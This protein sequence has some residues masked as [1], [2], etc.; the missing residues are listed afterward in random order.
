MSD[1]ESIIRLLEEVER[2][3]RKIGFCRDSSRGLA[4]FLASALVLKLWDLRYPLRGQIVLTA[5]GT[6][7]AALVARLGWRWFHKQRLVSIAASIDIK[8]Q[9]NDGMKSA[10]WFLTAPDASAQSSSWIGLHLHRTA[11]QSRRIDA[12]RLYPIVLPRGSYIA[13]ILFGAVVILNFMPTR[14]NHNWIYLKTAPAFALTERETMLVEQTQRLL[15]QGGGPRVA[16]TLQQTGT[17]IDRLESGTITL[18]EGLRRLDEI[19]HALEET[20]LDTAA[21]QKALA[22]IAGEFERAAPM[23]E[24]ARALKAP[25]LLTAAAQLRELADRLGRLTREE[26][27]SVRET[28]QHAAKADT[29]G[30]KT[31][32]QDFKQAAETGI[33]ESRGGMQAWLEKGAREL[34]A[35]D[36]QMHDQGIANAAGMEIRQL[37]AELGHHGQNDP[38]QSASSETGNGGKNQVSPQQAARGSQDTPGALADGLGPRDEAGSRQSTNLMPGG[39]AHAPLQIKGE[40]STLAVQL[41]KE[42]VSVRPDRG[43][44]PSEFEEATAVEKSRLEFSRLRALSNPPQEDVLDHNAIPWKYRDLVRTYFLAIQPREAQ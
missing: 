14:R 37:E 2:R 36:A 19:R 34:G 41:K 8:A 20:N 23:R 42:K 30:L 24:I 38:G 10:F 28:L 11:L 16:E 5:L 31:L 33:G 44:T 9:L 7:F 29:R 15:K 27:R 18:A 26:F 13:A 35:L 6:A 39:I 1:T 25:D 40:I 22:S 43:S 21:I 17:V 3:I 32:M 12:S 4:L